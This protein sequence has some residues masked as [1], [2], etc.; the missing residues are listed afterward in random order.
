MKKLVLIRHAKS[1]WSNILLDDFDRPLNKRGKKNAPF[2]AN[3]LNKKNLS[4]DLI[5]SSPSIRTKLTLEYFINEFN[6]TK[7]IVFEK[8]IYEAPFENLLNVIKSV[9]NKYNTIF[10]IGH[11]PGLNDLSNFLLNEFK[12]NI[13]TCGIVEIEFDIDFWKDISKRNSKLISF[14][15]PKKYI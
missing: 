9:N 4:P 1:D 11:N 15:F 6:Y 7:D 8:N 5:I 3:L 10:L 13:P 2:M 12:E 14:E